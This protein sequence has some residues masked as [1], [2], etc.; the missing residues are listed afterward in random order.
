MSPITRRMMPIT[1]L[2][3]ELIGR[4]MAMIGYVPITKEAYLSLK[5]ALQ[6]W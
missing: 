5:A 4:V 2:L 1:V 6:G 3:A